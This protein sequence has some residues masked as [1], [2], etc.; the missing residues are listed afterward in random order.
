MSSLQPLATSVL[1]TWVQMTE[2]VSQSELTADFSVN[3][4]KLHL[5]LPN[6]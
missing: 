1:R 2:S 3:E 4:A 5:P 6:N